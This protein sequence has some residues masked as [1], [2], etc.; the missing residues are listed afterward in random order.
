MSSSEQNHENHESQGAHGAH[1][2]Y[3]KYGNHAKVWQLL[4][5]YLNGTLAG[6]EQQFVSMHT[7]VCLVCHKELGLQRALRESVRAAELDDV[8]LATSF[9]RLSAQITAAASPLPTNVVGIAAK[10]VANVRL[11]LGKFPAPVYAAAAALVLA[12]GVGF[13]V[14]NDSQLP[15]N[16]TFRTLSSSTAQAAG[17]ANL[18][19]IFAEE[20][21]TSERA[22]ILQ[23][24]GLTAVA[25]PDERGMYYLKSPGQTPEVTEAALLQ[26]R[27]NEQIVFAESVLATAPANQ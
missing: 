10:M 16:N 14:V 25:G 27:A 15:I 12:V 23:Q 17:T 20:L 8:M 7:A 3:E 18:R 4:P 2:E 13:S 19:I 22:A 11:Q 1:G 9:E 26:L 24:S 21:S 5:W 6:D